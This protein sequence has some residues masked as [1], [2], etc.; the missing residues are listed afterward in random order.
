MPRQ[1]SHFAPVLRSWKFPA[2]PMVLPSPGP[3]FAS[4]VPAPDI[5]VMGSRPVAA[6]EIART[7]KLTKNKMKKLKTEEKIS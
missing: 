6:K 5:A 3:T 7:T 2:G 1:S 4:A